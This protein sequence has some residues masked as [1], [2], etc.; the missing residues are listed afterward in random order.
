MTLKEYLV[1]LELFLVINLGLLNK[2][3][4]LVGEVQGCYSALYTASSSPHQ[5]RKTKNYLALNVTMAEA[6]CTL[7]GNVCCSMYLII[8]SL[9]PMVK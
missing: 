6:G 2:L 8:Q 9:I 4:H 3:C 1:M 7:T 5:L